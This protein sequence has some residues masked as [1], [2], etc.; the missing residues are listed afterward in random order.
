MA[1]TDFTPDRN[2]LFCS[3]YGLKETREIINNI[4]FTLGAIERLA[5]HEEKIG[6]EELAAV[7]SLIDTHM[8]TVHSHCKRAEDFLDQMHKACFPETSDTPPTPT[9]FIH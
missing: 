8:E 7:L 1:A 4:M 5:A 6:H 9:T 2:T 3:W